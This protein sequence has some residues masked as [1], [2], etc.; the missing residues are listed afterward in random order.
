MITPSANWTAAFTKRQRK[1]L[2]LVEIEGYHYAFSN[3][4]YNPAHF[5]SPTGTLMTPPFALTGTQRVRWSFPS[6]ASVGTQD[7]GGNSTASP[8]GSGEVTMLHRGP[9]APYYEC[10]WSGWTSPALPADAVIVAMYP[11]VDY[12]HDSGGLVSCHVG[13]LWN[14][15]MFYGLDNT[16]GNHL[17]G[18]GLGSVGTH[19]SDLT[20]KT[21]TAHMEE[22]LGPG[23]A[24][25]VMTVNQVS[26]AIV[27]TSA[28]EDAGTAGASG[29]WPKPWMEPAPD[30]LE[31]SVDDLNG[32]ATL[33]QLSFNILDPKRLNFPI[34]ADMPTFV[35]EGKRMTFKMGTR[36]LDY[37]DLLPLFTGIV[38]SVSS[39]KGNLGWTFVCNDGSAKL[40]QVIWTEGDDGQP[41]D[42]DHPR[43]ISGNPLDIMLAIFT[44]LGL[45]ISE[46]DND[47]IVAYR[48]TYFAGMNLTFKIT[49]PPQAR[50]WMQKQ[51]MIP[52]GGILWVNNLG[53]YTV[54]FPFPLDGDTD[55]VMTLTKRDL[56]VTPVAGQAELINQISF[57][58]DKNDDNSGSSN[59]DFRSI[60]I[61]EDEDSID[62]Y[63]LFG[64]HVIDSDGLR[65]ANQGFFWAAFV[66]RTIFLR[67]GNKNLM[68]TGE[69]QWKLA[70]LEP[71]DLVLVSH[72]LVPDRVNG[73]FGITD[74][75]LQVMDRTLMFVPNKASIRFV[76]A[77]H[78]SRY[79]RFKFA[80]DDI[81][82]WTLATSDQKARYMFLSEDTGLMSNG[83]TAP[84]LG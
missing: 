44:L 29:S 22:S 13:F 18:Y 76:D 8:L 82:D 21:L 60:S 51:L 61:L 4:A 16:D 84:I 68:F 26:V 63:G 14:G 59:V 34:L 17:I 55:P 3:H 83:D 58:F 40:D 57:R 24:D 53:V 12:D 27:Y 32:A 49:S 69:G 2:Y 20:G 25:T 56:S 45:D 71:F 67:Y 36:D 9:F 19:L 65:S 54:R 6:S 75:L 42:S 23:D 39:M 66:G 79:G 11:V 81:P 70:L 10:Y 50:D 80:P 74:W 1:P 38:E 64:E 28:S 33:G 30:D 46:Y 41:T 62:K 48:D 52:L 15:S 43:T 47:R 35:F 77:S 5:P 73:V 7:S 78:M 37:P 31:L 72:P